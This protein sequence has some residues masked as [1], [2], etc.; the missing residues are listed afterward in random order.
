M[1]RVV[2][3]EP[4]TGARGAPPLA[5]QETSAFAGELLGAGWAAVFLPGEPARRGRLL[6]WKPTG[7]AAGDRVAP[8][9]LETETVELVL[10]HGRSV[11]RRRV[12]G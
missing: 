5:R 3:R 11:R 12:E 4:S 10:P 1:A 6:L 7:A 8:T 9:G 2:V